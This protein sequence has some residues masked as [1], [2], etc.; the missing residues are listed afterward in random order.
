ML[1]IYQR[2]T[3]RILQA[4]T[5]YLDLSSLQSQNRMLWLGK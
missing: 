2:Q 3:M 1:G 4:M 5:L